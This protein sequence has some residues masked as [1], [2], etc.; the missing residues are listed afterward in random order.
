MFARRH[1]R[2]LVHRPRG[3]I[4]I[5]V[6]DDFLHGDRTEADAAEDLSI[7]FQT[8]VALGRIHEAGISGSL[9]TRT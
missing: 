8:E 5:P 7:R 9:R 2:A 3:A 4:F 6:K 1:A